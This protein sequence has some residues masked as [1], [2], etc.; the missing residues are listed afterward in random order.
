MIRIGPAGW[1]Y[2]DW[3]GV[4]YPKRKPPGFHEAT[5]LAR[6][7]DTIELN[8]TYYRPIPASTAESWVAK[9]ESNPRFRYTAKL[10][11]GFTHER[12]ATEADARLFVD[13]MTPLLEAGR[14]GAVLM[15][16]PFSFHNTPETRDYVAR[17]GERFSRFPL[18]LEVRHASW[19][20]GDA[21]AM[22]RE[23]GIGLCN[24]DQ[25]LFDKSVAPSAE[26]TSATG[27]IRLHGR[28]YETWFSADTQT[29]E[30]YNY[31]YT[32][33]ELR[34]WVNRIDDVASETDDVYVI[35]NNHYLGK[36]VVNA[37]E[38]EALLSG[39]RVPVPEP[40]LERYPTLHAFAAG[41]AANQLSL[42]DSKRVP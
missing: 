18:V 5:Y 31:L 15:Q 30:R 14:L 20:D 11:R 32:L 21:L 27:Y 24:I 29:S 35:A 6:Y 12:N 17:L 7:F 39:S 33:D 36:A 38:I 8:V 3:S 28:R 1:A 13:G 10:W 40:L 4:V 23:L 2:K 42:L 9:V 22:L 26:A 25:P 19:Q 41:E 34:P 37:L 16:F